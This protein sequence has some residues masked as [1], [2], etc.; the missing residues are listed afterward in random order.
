MPWAASCASVRVEVGGA[1]RDVPVGGA[2][3]VVVDAEV[4]GQL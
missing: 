4:V 1:D 2:E 3:L